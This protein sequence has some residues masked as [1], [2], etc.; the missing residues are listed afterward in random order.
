MGAAALTGKWVLKIKRGAQDEIKH[1]KARYLVRGFERIHGKEYHETWAPGGHYTTLTCL[2]VIC[3][4]EGLGT[5]HLDMKCAFQNGRL[6]EAMYICQ[7]GELGDGTGNV[8]S[9]KKTLYGLKQAAREW[10]KVLAELLR[11][12]DFARC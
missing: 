8:W 9:L 11:D 1:F 6:T 4:H 3:V 7:P 10:H 12:L 5:A 2:L